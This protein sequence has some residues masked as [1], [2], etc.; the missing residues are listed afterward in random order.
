MKD[1]NFFIRAV[2][3]LA[4][5]GIQFA[6]PSSAS[7][8]SCMMPSSPAQTFIDYDAVF[9]GKVVAISANYSP[10]ISFLD[11]MLSFLNL[12][13]TYFYTDRFWGYD[14]TLALNK[15]W[16]GITTTRVTL[17][18]GSGGGDCGYSFNQGSDYLV[19]AYRMQNNSDN[20][21]GVSICSRTTEISRA[22]EDLTYLNTIPTLQLTPVYD[23][24]WLYF[25]G[26]G[27]FALTVLLW[28]V[29][30]LRR[31]QQR[32]ANEDHL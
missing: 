6:V 20:D 15:S 21:L 26:T 5:L 7:A 3:C 31:W 22:T 27:L 14:V 29:F 24:S 1:K 12:H 9:T 30:V 23:Y 11:R 16:K 19:Y 10:V 4:L 32:Q 13:P 2:L 28:L 18:T 17:H 8:C 25:A